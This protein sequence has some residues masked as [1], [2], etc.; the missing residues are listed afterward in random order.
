MKRFPRTDAPAADELA[1]TSAGP[2][3]PE[4]SPLTPLR[5]RWVS[6]ESGRPEMRWDVAVG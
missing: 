5:C 2:R 4:T 6:G 3:A 1:G